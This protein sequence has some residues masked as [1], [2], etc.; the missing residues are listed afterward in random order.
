M[1]L[2]KIRR[3]GKLYVRLLLGITLSIVLLLVVS[4]SVY[5]FIFSRVLQEEAFDSDLGNLR[6]TGSTV[7]NTTQS[8]Q[9][10]AF[11]IYRNPTINR[12]LYY[13]QPDAFDIQGSILSLRSYL[14][15]MPFIDS[16]YIYN[17]SSGQYIIAGQTG[18]EGVF[19]ES[20]IKDEEIVGILDNY[21]VY[22][23]FAPVPRFITSTSADA[24]DRGVYTF[25]C[26]DAIGFERKINSA[27]IVNISA[28]W[29]NRELGSVI[30]AGS[31][32]TFLV[33]DR[34]AIL[35]VNNLTNV[36]LE[37]KDAELIKLLGRS[38]EAGFKI[39]DF[40][41]VKSLITYTAPTPYDWHYVRVT[42]YSEVTAKSLEIRTTTLQIASVILAVGLLLAWIMSRY[43]Y[44]PIHRI[45]NRM[46]DLES[47]RRNSTYTLRQNTLRK[48]IQIQEFDSK[49]QL[50]KLRNTGITFDFTMPYRLAYLRIDRFDRI[51]DESHKD[52]LTFKFAI[53]NIATEICSKQYNVESVDLED[54]G[55]LMLFNTF[56]DDHAAPESLQP[57]L[58]DIQTACMEYIRIGMTVTLTPMSKSPHELHAMFKLA[59]ETSNQRFFQGRGAL[60][61]ASA[62]LRDD[63][64]SFSV[65][66]ERKMLDA[67]VSG[68]TD[69]AT[70]LFREI[71]EE[72]AE[73]PFRV[74]HSAANHVTVSLSNMLAEIERNGLRLHIGTEL[75]IPG[76][77]HHETLDE[78]TTAMQAFFE[79][80]KTK[81]FEKR[82]NKQ[83]DL[84]RKINEIIT[85]RFHDPN[86]SLNYVSDEL[87]MS[88]YHISRVYRQHTLTNIVDMINTI[89]IEKAK[90]FLVR[91][92][93]PV[94]EIAERTGY[95]N[96]SYFH[97]MFKK[98]TG[99]TPAEFRKAN[100]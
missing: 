86:L 83:E 7:A 54:D 42:P 76:I 35:T 6:Q 3:N 26:Y 98:T 5:Y 70:A 23:P 50:E 96:S 16:I 40:D 100:H 8:A 17:E 99:V 78:L 20:E 71:M 87:K 13:S 21:Q 12:M 49:I 80:L 32:R 48:L 46:I 60:I 62:A 69:E 92:D 63:K 91:T 34:N 45:E 29:I 61:E 43:L 84:I 57:M 53:M 36:D 41:G 73:H 66:K 2:N 77:E 15:T 10:V 65:V 52:M 75:I 28:S 74:T 25:L 95:T 11:Q 56:E 59:K 82:S 33:D 27:V 90:E 14:S 22:K 51:R 30:S 68:K 81:A 31:D 47:E 88:S 18:Q 1:R 89:R 72:T 19:A 67:L 44:V 94:S 97:R 64:H 4:S 39:A 58:R 79:T 24:T 93:E 85:T 38:E 9:T 37:E 55:I